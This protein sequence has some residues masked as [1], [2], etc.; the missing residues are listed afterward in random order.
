MRSRL[1]KLHDTTQPN[2][3]PDLAL[4]AATVAGLTDREADWR[5]QSLPT[6]DGN[7]GQLSLYISLQ[8]R[9]LQFSSLAHDL[10][11]YA[12]RLLVTRRNSVLTQAAQAF[13]D[14]G[15]TPNETR[16]TRTLVLGGDS[17]LRVRYFDLLLHRDPAALTALAGSKA[18]RHQPRRRRTQLERGP[19][20]LRHRRW[21]PS[22]AAARHL[23][24]CGVPASA[25]LV[26]TYF[27][28]S[29]SGPVNLA[30]DFKQ[31]L[32]ANSTIAASPGRPCRS[33][34]PTHRRRL[35]YYAS[36]YGIFLATV[37]SNT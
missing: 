10:E 28:S 8:Q 37:R 1:D 3:N 23:V 5:K 11:V 19:R 2:A 6:G 20:L 31:A 29:A 27:A 13:R 17:Q 21:L 24:R 34:A 36:R 7:F 22:P 16:L 32:A 15:D 30:V 18:Q 26:Q 9:R 14:A 35:F 25:S 33:H 4:Q 12:A